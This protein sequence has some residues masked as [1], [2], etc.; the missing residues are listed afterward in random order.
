[1]NLLT[2]DGKVDL[3][4]VKVLEETR[5][6]SMELSF[7]IA[8]FITGLGMFCDQCG[9]LRPVDGFYPLC[10][11]GPDSISGCICNSCEKEMRGLPG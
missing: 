11:S 2:P 3:E 6:H 1:M 9:D 5:K 7:L 4:A 10:S 8:G